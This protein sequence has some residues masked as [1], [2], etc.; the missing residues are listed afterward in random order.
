MGSPK[1][2]A[3]EKIY[4]RSISLECNLAEVKNPFS[5]LL[6]L[7]HTYS[8]SLSPSFYRTSSL[9][10]SPAHKFTHTHACTWAATHSRTRVN[11]ESRSWLCAMDGS[12]DDKRP[13]FNF[14]LPFFIG[15][16]FQRIFNE[17]K[18]KDVKKCSWNVALR[19]GIVVRVIK[20]IIPVP[21]KFTFI[22]NTSSSLS[23]KLPRHYIHQKY[24]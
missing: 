10:H 22:E 17:R 2:K 9:T 14:F 18:M 19:V 3:V 21:Q 11:S 5:P 15:L 12:S 16:T 23:S 6:S 1:A 4:Q 24:I 7:S 8:I 13:F 20:C